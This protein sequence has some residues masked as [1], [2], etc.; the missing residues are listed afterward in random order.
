MKSTLFGVLNALYRP[1]SGE[2][3]FKGSPMSYRHRSIIRMR[4]E[5]SI[6]FQNPNDMMFKPY[7][8]QDVAHGPSNMRLPKDVRLIADPVMV[9]GAR[10]AV[11]RI[12]SL[13]YGK[14][15][16]DIIR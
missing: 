4:S 14:I 11:E 8:G 9:D 16:F 2:V 12:N 6:L 3:P 10:K 1:E 5:A 13:G 7:V 15:G